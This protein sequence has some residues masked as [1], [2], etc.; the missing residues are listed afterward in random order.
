[1]EE[2][3]LEAEGVE[4]IVGTYEEFVLGYKISVD[5]KEEDGKPVSWL[6]YDGLIIDIIDKVEFDCF[7]N[8]NWH[9][10]LRTTLIVE[11]FVRLQLGG[12]I[13]LQEVRMRPL[14]LSIWG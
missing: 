14:D 8:I 9:K 13:S 1:M 10:A 11:V 4:I 6:V 5:G 7:R 12:N 3:D 2:E